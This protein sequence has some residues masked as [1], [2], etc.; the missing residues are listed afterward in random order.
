MRWLDSYNRK[1]M[2]A[3]EAVRLIESNDR[4][5][6]HPGCAV[7]E[8]LVNAMV[9]RANELMNVEVIH[10]LN[11]GQA[12]YALPEMEGHFRHNALFI[13]GNVRQAVNEGRADFTPIFLSEIPSL[14]RNGRL[15]IDVALV[16]LSPP[17]EHGF[18]S[19]GL[20]VETTKAAAENAKIV[21]AQ[22]NPQMPRALGDCFIH[23]NKLTAIVEAD[24]PLFE[25]PQFEPNVTNPEYIV[26][27][28]IGEHIA[29]LIE[30]GST[31]QMGIGMIPDAVLNFLVHK[32]DLGIHTEMFSDGVVELVEKGIINNE[33]KT[34]HR[35]KIVASFVLGS[36]KTYNFL[37]NNPLCEFHPSDYVNDVFVIAQ[38]EKMVAINSAVEVD[39]TGQVCS[40]S[41]GFRL[42]SGFGGQ[43]DFIRGASRSKGGKPII[44]LPSTTADGKISRICAHLKIGAGVVTTRADVHYV[45]TEY[46]YADL[47]GKCIRERAKALINIAHPNYREELEKFAWERHWIK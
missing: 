36:K 21:I 43:L 26:A 1:K 7:P 18:C 41:I 44:A 38:N 31:L 12:R 45:V 22:I 28:K 5:Y 8:L 6:V 2:S 11:M 9:Q 32:R 46:G 39:L 17:D 4:V 33:K 13:G 23:I 35:G 27:Q 20:G 15:P 47:Y 10:I 3:E 30:D 40:D 25:L 24:V 14:F 19:F 34:L 29:E 42:Y 16:H 37:D